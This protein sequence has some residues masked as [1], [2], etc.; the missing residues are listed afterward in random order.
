MDDLEG[1]IWWCFS[2]S[3]C[4]SSVDW[5]F[6]D[7]SRHSTTFAH[8]TIRIMIIIIWMCRKLAMIS[9]HI[10]WFRITQ[11]WVLLWKTHH[12]TTYD[13]FFIC[14]NRMDSFSFAFKILKNTC[15]MAKTMCAIFFNHEIKMTSI[16]FSSSADSTSDVSVIVSEFVQ[17]M[18]ITKDVHSFPQTS[19]SSKRKVSTRKWHLD[20][21]SISDEIENRER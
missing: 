20:F 4:L 7:R 9:I 17:W 3:E 5:D 15:V 14:R 12:F 11:I 6:T 19:I 21:F 10:S 8:V 1:W 16:V 2:L 13:G 18:S